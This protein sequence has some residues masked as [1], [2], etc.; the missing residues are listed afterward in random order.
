M[1]SD[2]TTLEST[3]L[4]EGHKSLHAQM[5]AWSPISPINFFKHYSNST[6][7]IIL[8]FLRLSH[9]RTIPAGTL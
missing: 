7:M 2:P 1:P 8:H 4:D 9:V 3:E 5:Y 6:N